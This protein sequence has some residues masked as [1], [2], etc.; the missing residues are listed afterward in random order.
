M[1]TYCSIAIV[2]A[3][4]CV[5]GASPAWAQFSQPRLNA[6]PGPAAVDSGE[7]GQAWSSEYE[8]AAP[9]ATPLQ[10]AQQKS[11]MRAAQRMERLASMK[12]YGF[13]AA[14]PRTEATPFT[15]MYG[16]QW[17]GRSLGRPAAWHAS[18]PSVVITR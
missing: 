18:R 7:R 13:S 1:R 6:D 4:A 15:G 2:F 10:I 16:A 12:W 9:V 8:S 17:Q 11:Q 14:R 5:L 3:A